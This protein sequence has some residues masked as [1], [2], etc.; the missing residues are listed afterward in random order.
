M[1][2]HVNTINTILNQSYLVYFNKNL[3]WFLIFSLILLSVYFNFNKSGYT[4]F[5]TNISILT[6]FLL[7]F[8]YS[9]LIFTNFIEN[10]FTE[11]VFSFIFS[12]IVSNIIKYITE[13]KSKVKL[14]KALSE[15]VSSDVA[16]EI[17]S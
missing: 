6:I 11:L 3:E 4:L 17:L 16:N 14:N 9:I 10:Y 15:Y 5:F 7:I 8:P 1:Y 13:N 12:I 2:V